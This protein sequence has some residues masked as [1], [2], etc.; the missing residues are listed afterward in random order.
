MLYCSVEYY[1]AGLHEHFVSVRCIRGGYL[2]QLKYRNFI[3]LY[4]Q[5][6]FRQKLIHS[7]VIITATLSAMDPIGGILDGSTK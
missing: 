2:K 3:L 4:V 7:A 1:L 6:F 5:S